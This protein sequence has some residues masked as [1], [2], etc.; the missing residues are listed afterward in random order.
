ML[1]CLLREICRDEGYEFNAFSGDWII[2]IHDSGSVSFVFGYDF[3]LNNATSRMIGADKAATAELLAAAAIPAVEHRLFLTPQL[4]T[5]IGDDGNWESIHDFF[6]QHGRD[7][8]CKPNDG[9]G[10]R[11]VSRVRTIQ[12]L[13]AAV[14]RLFARN[15]SICLS[16]FVLITAEY[17]VYMMGGTAQVVYAKE[18][19]SVVGDGCSTTL[20]LALRN[21]LYRTDRGVEISRDGFD[22]TRV[23][24]EGEEVLLNWRHNLGQGG[25]ARLLGEHHG[26]FP[27][28]SSLAASATSTLGIELA[29]VDIVQIGDRFMVLE[30]NCGIMMESFARSSVENRD[31]AKQFYRDILKEALNRKAR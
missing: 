7:V 25:S 23:P 20:E 11:D 28:L 6:I 30:V 12:Q 27:V 31:L 10:G 21:G 1:V 17:R 29:A 3:G 13:E 9:T 14:H 26:L 18:R 2:R 16:P 22:A 8:V 24:G 4:A 15:R 5:Y 19:P